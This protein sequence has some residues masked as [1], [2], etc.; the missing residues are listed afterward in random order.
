MGIV[1]ARKGDADAI[2]WPRNNEVCTFEVFPNITPPR[3][4]LSGITNADFAIIIQ[5]ERKQF[6]RVAQTSE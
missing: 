3:E 1:P 6:I 5:G 2:E 4:S